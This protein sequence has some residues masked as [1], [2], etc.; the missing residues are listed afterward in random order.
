MALEELLLSLLN[1][2]NNIGC[3]TIGLIAG[4]KMIPEDF[5]EEYG[6]A[7]ATRSWKYVS[8]LVHEDVCVTFSNGAYFRGKAEVQKAFEKN[9]ALI[10]DE[11]YSVSDVHWVR[12]TEQYAVYIYTFHW[13]GFID[14]KQVEGAGRGTSVLIMENGKWLL[15]AEHLGPFAK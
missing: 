3:S 14:G 8:P 11:K 2:D 13:T 4:E 12:K 1:I 7:L 10:K 5:I 15:L 9:F 6:A